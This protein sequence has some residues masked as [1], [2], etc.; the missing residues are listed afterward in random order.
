MHGEMDT[1]QALPI[2]EELYGYSVQT[3][4]VEMDTEQAL[5]RYEELHGYSM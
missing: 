3:I 2:Y 1:D 5:S 4:P